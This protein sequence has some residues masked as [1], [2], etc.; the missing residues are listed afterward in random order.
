MLRE[1]YI[2]PSY[3]LSCILPSLLLTLLVFQAGTVAYAQVAPKP[4]TLHTTLRNAQVW[5]ELDFSDVQDFEDATRGFIAGLESPRWIAN[6]NTTLTQQGFYAW[7]MEAYLSFM[8]GVTCPPSVN[9]S[10]WRQETLN[11]LNGLFEVLPGSIY[12]IRSYDMATMSFVKAPHG[13]IVIDP[14]M[15]RE[16]SRAGLALFRVHVSQDPIVAIIITHSHH[17]HYNGVPGILQAEAKASTPPGGD[18]NS[19]ATIPIYAPEGF[20]T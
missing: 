11:N 8:D 17:D 14:L 3:A 9:P 20:F 5:D 12:Q 15:S 10:L 7:N 13:W 6:D 19:M 4:P 18:L 16:T 1:S 2:K